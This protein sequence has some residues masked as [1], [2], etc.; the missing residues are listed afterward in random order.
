MHEAAARRA[1]RL[2]FGG[3]AQVEEDCRDARG[4]MWIESA[5]ADLR[6]ALRTLRRSPG[7]AFAAIATLAL[8]IGANTAIF[9]VVYAVLLKPLPYARPAELVAIAS[10]IPEMRERF[11]S[12]PVTATDFVEFRRDSTQAGPGGRHRPRRFQ[13]DRQWRARAYLRRAEFPPISFRCSVSCPSAAAR[14]CPRKTTPAA[15]TW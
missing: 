1:A 9:S 15:T 3:L 7:F 6:Y 5:L 2:E 13:Y 14:S 8:G 12:L 4:T 10:Y 11:P